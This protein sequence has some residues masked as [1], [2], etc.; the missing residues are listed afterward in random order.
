MVCFGA[1]DLIYKRAAMRGVDGRQFAMLQSWVFVPS[2]TAYAWLTGTLDVHWSAIWGALAGFFL[3]VAVVNFVASLQSGAVSTTAPVFR[4]NFAIT[5]ALAILLLGETLNAAK[6]TA[7]AATLGAVWLLLAVP[8]AHSA[9]VDM[10]SLTRVLVAT[11]AMGCGNFCYK[12]GVIAGASPET[13][14]A[15][16]GWLFGPAATLLFWIE[17]R[18]FALT[19]GAW[20]HTSAAAIILV[21]GFI[22]LLHGLATGYAS[23]LVPVAQM[24]FVVTALLGAAIFHEPLTGRKYL[25]LA[26]TAAALSLFAAS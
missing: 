9:S 26:V 21:A 17:R 11:L 2:V 13:M 1:S 3:L 24:S 14:I 22:L 20:R 6:I 25:G 10:K 15:A 8:R 16:Q 23:V 19:A 7:L 4:L 18:R 12:L 5:V